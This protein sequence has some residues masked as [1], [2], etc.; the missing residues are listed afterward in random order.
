MANIENGYLDKHWQTAQ[1]ELN[2][3]ISALLK[4]VG[5]TNAEI[6]PLYQ[7]MLW[8]IVKLIQEDTE[9][10]DIKIINHTLRELEKA[11]TALRRFKRRR[12]VTIYGS[13]RTPTGAPE[14]QLAVG[15]GRELAKHNFMAITGAGNGIM[16]AAHEGAG[17]EN[18]LGFNITLP[19]EQRVN[20]V[21][22]ESEGLVN[23]K[24]FFTRKL[25]FVKEADAL[26][27]FPGGFGTLDEAFELLTLVQTGKSPIVPIILMD[28]PGGTYWIEWRR[29]MEK[30]LLQGKYI[31][32]HDMGLVE[33]TTD[34]EATIQII[35]NFYHNYH[36]LR[37]VGKE[38]RLRINRPLPKEA[39][40]KLNEQFSHVLS[41]GQFTQEPPHPSE[42]DETELENMTRLAFQ[43]N[44]LDY[45]Q[46]RQVINFVN[47]Y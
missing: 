15:L 31:D 9:R 13:A 5:V 43:F 1:P 3:K 36:S 28:V 22:E 30:A 20:P 25:F 24:F 27:L 41:Q 26:V 35:S 45:G 29:F 47:Q 16:G 39:L 23:F 42:K 4:L 14:Y 21:I 18:S 11:F 32:P 6:S 40:Q 44:A 12:K 37:W 8:S 17:R 19:F 7:E 10:W 46:L 2:E 33:Y 38:L 34:P